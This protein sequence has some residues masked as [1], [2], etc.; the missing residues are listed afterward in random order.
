MDQMIETRHDC[1]DPSTIRLNCWA[2]KFCEVKVVTQ[3]QGRSNE[4]RN[5]LSSFFITV[6]LALTTT[7]HY[8]MVGGMFN[9]FHSHAVNFFF[10]WC[11]T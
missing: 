6:K 4:K 5:L 10:S 9:L 11:D 2:P 7:R 3:Q 8:I 1:F